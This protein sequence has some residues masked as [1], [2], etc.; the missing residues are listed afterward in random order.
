MSYDSKLLR[1]C[2]H[3]IV[4]EDHAVDIDFKTVYLNSFVA[5]MNDASVRVNNVLWD[6]NNK[7]EVLY[8]QD[9]T[10]QILG[11][12]SNFV[13]SRVPVYNG[14]NKKQIASR[15][16]D[17]TVQVIVHDE[18][19]SA[20]FTGTDKLLVTQHRPLMSSYNIFAVQLT[21]NDVTVIVDSV[22]VDIDSIEPKYG[23]IMLKEAPV[24]GATVTVTYSYKAKVTSFNANTGAIV[25]K[26][27]PALGHDVLVS[28]Y[29]LA[30]DGWTIVNDTTL[31]SST[32]VFD[33][34]KQTNNILVQN[35]DDSYQFTGL[36]DRFYT[37]NKP[38][39]P[40]RSKLSTD[41]STT[42]VT[43]IIVKVNG[44][45]V[46]PLNFDPNTGLIV[47]GL[48]PK[49]TD[50]VTVT[51]N[52]RSV[53]PTDIISVSY[54]V[55]VN[56]CKKC[57]RT[58]QLNDFDYDKLGELITVQD[59][60]KLMQD[61]L[62]FTIAIKGSNKAHSWWG[63]SLV[64]YIG[65][66]KVQEYY[67]PKFKSEI[68]DG[69]SKIKDLQLQQSQYQEVTDEEFFSYFDN[70]VVQQS[71]YDYNFYEISASIVSQ[72]ATAIAM[73]TTLYFNKPLM[74]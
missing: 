49:T 22:I 67:D 52:Y 59:E 4:E 40:P 24:F 55:D 46:S 14:A 2:D 74:S 30:P 70:I 15:T 66:A 63:T 26:E 61:V 47:L 20:Q 71:D 12:N 17:A 41:P 3:R 16:T 68:I 28:Y 9:V 23:K 53:N 27:T 42:M 73:N 48:K 43:Q 31:K 60:Q 39:I 5:N 13:V 6:K 64:S 45:R 10:S 8:E 1:Y 56:K 11:T 29:Y 58:G 35:E 51:Y 50:A 34:E 7:S 72:A 65:T 57:K 37:Q 33:R 18:D 25:V 44:Q 36:E 69:G 32:L 21:A 19:A 38:I 62:K 54:Q